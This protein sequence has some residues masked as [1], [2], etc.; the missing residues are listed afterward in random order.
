MKVVILAAGYGTR[1]GSLTKDKPKPLVDLDGKPLIEHIM[2]RL[3][4]HGLTEV[5]VNIH[6]LPQLLPA[7][8]HERALYFYEPKLLGHTLH[9]LA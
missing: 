4:M 6:Y 5:I 9:S 1:L 8:L 2:T 7:Y 3:A